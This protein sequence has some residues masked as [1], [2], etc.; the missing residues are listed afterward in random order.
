MVTGAMSRVRFPQRRQIMS[1]SS[2]TPME[3]H[4]FK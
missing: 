4:R 3:T 2:G 1:S